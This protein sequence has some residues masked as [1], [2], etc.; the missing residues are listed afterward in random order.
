[1]LRAIAKDLNPKDFYEIHSL[2]F[3]LI[4]MNIFTISRM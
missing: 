2:Y 4:A 1:M 3:P